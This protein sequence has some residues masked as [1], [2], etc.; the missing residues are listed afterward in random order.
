MQETIILL[1]ICPWNIKLLNRWLEKHMAQLSAPQI[2]PLL[3]AWPMCRKTI[4]NHPAFARLLCWFL[5]WGKCVLM[6]SA[7]PPANSQYRKKTWAVTQPTPEDSTSLFVCADGAETQ[8]HASLPLQYMWKGWI[9]YWLWSSVLA[10]KQIMKQQVHCWRPMTRLN[11]RWRQSAHPTSSAAYSP[12]YP[13]VFLPLTLNT[14]L[15]GHRTWDWVVRWS[16]N[17][18]MKAGWRSVLSLFLTYYSYF[19]TTKSVLN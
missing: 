11:K 14:N 18:G 17:S 8:T 9:A 7:F 5:F 6:D 2:T 3:V 15:S 19:T 16:I 13:T 1:K 10:V 12:R 4:Q